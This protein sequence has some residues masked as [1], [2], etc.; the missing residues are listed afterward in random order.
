MAHHFGLDPRV[1]RCSVEQLDKHGFE[2]YGARGP[3][4]LA[5]ELTRSSEQDS[6]LAGTPQDIV[7]PLPPCGRCDA[8]PKIS[9]PISATM[10]EVALTSDEGAP[11]GCHLHFEVRPKGGSYDQA[12][13][14]HSVVDLR[15]RR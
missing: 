15:L 6:G 14:P 2:R 11:D 12:V 13:N 4:S 8:Q 5:S 10:S 7:T 3:G 9:E 1:K